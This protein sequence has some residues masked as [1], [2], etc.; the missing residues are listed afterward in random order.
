M[1][2]EIESVKYVWDVDGIK[3][4]TKGEAMGKQLKRSVMD[5]EMEV[6][7]VTYLEEHGKSKYSGVAQAVIAQNH[8]LY[9]SQVEH[10]EVNVTIK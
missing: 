7:V 3:V 4:K 2:S 10:T 5:L 8:F 1:Q 6:R 9:I